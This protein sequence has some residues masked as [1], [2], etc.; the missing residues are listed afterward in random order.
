MLY[1]ATYNGDL[2]LRVDVSHSSKGT[3]E[4][5]RKALIYTWYQNDVTTDHPVR[6]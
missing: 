1:S 5:T 3:S 6:S 4:T 2:V